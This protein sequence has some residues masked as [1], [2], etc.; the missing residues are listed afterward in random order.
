MQCCYFTGFSGEMLAAIE[1]ELVSSLIGGV[2]VATEEISEGVVEGVDE[3]LGGLVGF[4]DS[5][6][7]VCWFVAVE[8]DVNIGWAAD[9]CC[10]A[11]ELGGEV[12]FWVVSISDE[13]AAEVVV[14]SAE[15]LTT[16]NFSEELSTGGGS[17]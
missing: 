10:A 5:S 15:E 7:D 13:E 8:A 2:I 14:I 4:A 12:V 9:F 6:E 11:G 17:V 16:D 3:V 1:V